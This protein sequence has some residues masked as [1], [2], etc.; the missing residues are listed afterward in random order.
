MNQDHSTDDELQLWLDQ[1]AQQAL[2]ERIEREQQAKLNR[3]SSFEHMKYNFKV[4]L[5]AKAIGVA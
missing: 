2:A 3:P 4:H 1:Q 5:Y